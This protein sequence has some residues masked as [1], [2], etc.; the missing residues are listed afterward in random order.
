MKAGR[1]IRRWVSTRSCCKD[2]FQSIRILLGKWAMRENVEGAG[3]L[4]DLNT[5]LT[6]REH[7]WK[8]SRT[9]HPGLLCK[10][11]TGSSGQSRPSEE[12]HLSIPAVLCCWLGATCGRYGLG[13]DMAIDFR[14][15]TGVLVVGGHVPMAA[16]G[17]YSRSVG[18]PWWWLRLA[19][20]V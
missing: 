15:V 13:R 4:S 19:L 12:A 1:P 18:E 10:A 7:E 3:E 8:Q 5:Y 9:K 11:G 16:T 2:G 14:V 6:L 17:G 20:A